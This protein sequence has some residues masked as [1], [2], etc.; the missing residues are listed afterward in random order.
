MVP[1]IDGTIGHTIKTRKHPRHGTQSVI[2]YPTNTNPAQ[3]LQENAITVFGARL[4]NS[5]PKFLR[6]IESV[7]TEISEFELDKN[8]WSSFLISQKCP[9]MS[10][11]QEATASSTSSHIWGL[12][13]FTKVVESPIRPRSSHSRFDTTPSI[14]VLNHFFS[15]NCNFGFPFSYFDLQCSCNKPIS[16]YDNIKNNFKQ[17]L[18]TYSQEFN[19]ELE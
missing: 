2:Q 16:H 10:P 3:S 1:N 17:N 14:Q 6:D 15:R 7:K 5:L 19:R 13:E 12:K 8:F 18:F 11:H 9:T 4:Y